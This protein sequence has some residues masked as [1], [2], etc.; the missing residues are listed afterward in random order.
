MAFNQLTAIKVDNTNDAGR[1]AD[2]GGLYLNVS[3]K[4]Q[5]S[6]LYRYSINGKRRW[7][8]LGAYHKKT[9]TLA[10]ARAAAV[11]LKLLISQNI[12]PIAQR[13]IDKNAQQEEKS[14]ADKAENLRAKTFKVCAEAHIKRKTPEWSNDKHIQQWSNSLKTYAY[15]HLG[16]IPVNDIEIGDIRNVLDPIWQHKTET[17]TRVRQR[18]EAIISYAIAMGYRQYANPATWKGLLDNFYPNP[19]KVK[20][21]KYDKMGSEKHHNALPYAD[22][23]TFMQ[24]LKATPGS[25]AAALQFTI[26]TASRTS[27]VIF[28]Q[29][30]E[31]NLDKKEWNIPKARMKARVAHRVALSDDAIALLKSLPK[32]SQYIFP[33]W[34]TGKPL[35][36]AAMTAVL[37]RMDRKDITVHGFRSTF[38]DYIGEE[39]DYPHRLAEYALA[40]SLKDGAEKAYAR[41]D[42]F[43][44]RIDMM[45]TWANYINAPDCFKGDAAAKNLSTEH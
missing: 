23:Y 32:T 9:N 17:A 39:T 41:G 13:A 3:A 6:W 21:K 44:K 19:E 34:I 18:I 22:I 30:D 37:R 25:G 10:M 26:L 14:R 27:E 28:A 31:L 11:K 16:D 20:Q 7:H 15:P 45:N 4:G 8:G 2:G 29:W 5:K 36:N 1:H 33:G 43:K 12:D 40:H 35:S 24:L 42:M 38:R